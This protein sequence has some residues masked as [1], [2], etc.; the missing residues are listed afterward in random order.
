MVSNH[1]GELLACQLTI[2]NVDARRPAP[3]VS[4]ERTVPWKDA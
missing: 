4:I 3:S 1:H 2:G